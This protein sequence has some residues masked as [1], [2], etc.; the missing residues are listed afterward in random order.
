MANKRPNNSISE[1]PKRH[2]DHGATSSSSRK[3]KEDADNLH[4]EDPFEDEFLSEDENENSTKENN[5]MN[6]DTNDDA[7]VKKEA[8]GV[9]NPLERPLEEGE[10]LEYDNS[11]YTMFHS[12][13][14]EWPCLSV[15]FIKDN[16][17]M[18][19]TKFPMTAY[20]VGG[21]QADKPE[22]NKLTIMKIS[23]MGRTY[24]GESDDESDSDVDEVEGDPVIQTRSLPHPGAC[25]RVRVMPQKPHIVATWSD[26]GNVYIWDISSLLQQ[27]DGHSGGTESKRTPLFA[28]R[29]HTSEGYA[30][31]WSPVKMGS[32]LSGDCNGTILLTEQNEQGQWYTNTKKYTAHSDSVEDIQWSSTEANVFASCSVD[33]TIR[34]WDT[35][36]KESDGSA[37]TIQDA[38][39]TDVNVISWN[40]LVPYLIVSGADD[41]SFKIWDL[42]KFTKGGT[43]R[44]D[45]P[46]GHFKWHKA[47][48]SSVAW[49]SQDD[50]MLAVACA[51]NSVSIWDMSVEA[52]VCFI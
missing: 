35:R 14:T 3:N 31:D 20:M 36:A 45:S 47:P 28:V 12:L 7:D 15:A 17:G 44:P 27:L 51:D 38:H 5:D 52:G 10:T 13:K 19:R 16:L 29:N 4:F 43:F 24:R 30:L 23:Q 21:T 39:D 49:H 26:D 40:K 46:A 50:S 41:G 1:S 32:L 34:V 25:N 9:W 2:R 6:M 37:I 8:T 11:A 18:Q 42:R 33:K 22:N 48:V